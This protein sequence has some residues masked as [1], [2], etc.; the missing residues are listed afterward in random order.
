MLAGVFV[1]ETMVVSQ[2]QHWLR[3]FTFHLINFEFI[4]TDKPFVPVEKRRPD[5]EFFDVS[6]ITPKRVID[7]ASDGSI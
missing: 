5:D 6:S 1:G 7:V 2:T 3:Y 4:M